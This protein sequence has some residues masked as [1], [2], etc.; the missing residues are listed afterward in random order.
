[1]ELKERLVDNIS[2]TI[3]VNYMSQI[4]NR[5]T[6]LF[7]KSVQSN[8]EQGTMA[9][10][11]RK[12]V[13]QKTE[14]V[15]EAE[16]LKTVSKE[17]MTLDEYREYISN[18]IA[19]FPLHPSQLGNSF[20]INISDVS[21]QKMK[22]D[23]E[24]EEWLLNDVKSAFGSAVPGWYHA[25]GGPSTYCVLN[26]ENGEKG[27]WCHMWSTGYK[28][29]SSDAKTMFDNESK[30]SV[31]TR[32]AERQKQIEKE[33]RKKAQQK[34]D[35]EKELEEK[36]LKAKLRNQE[37]LRDFYNQ[38]YYKNSLMKGWS[39]LPKLDNPISTTAPSPISVSAAYEASFLT[40]EG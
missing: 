17:D 6:S 4:T 19:G 12:V 18:K 16:E 22:D 10:A 3:N 33:L 7:S 11:I 5:Y 38:K 8:K 36:S 26:Y 2:S 40:V 30:D 31:Y 28:G 25:I 32:R 1:M 34:K 20:S 37:Y 27:C 35:Y 9:D 24:Y 39:D 13:S 15:A 29:G 14:N 23:P 21:L